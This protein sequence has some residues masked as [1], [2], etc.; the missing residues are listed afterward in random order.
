MSDATARILSHMNKDHSVAVEDYLS[1]YGGVTVDNKVANV[2]MR[3][4]ELDHM[5]IG[6]NH[7]LI[8][9]EVLKPIPFDPPMKS[10]REARERLVAMAK[11]AAAK[12]GYSHI[13][14]NEMVYPPK[15]N[16]P[17]LVLTVLL[18]WGFFKPDYLY[19]VV[20]P[21]VLPQPVTDFVRFL[22]P[23]SFYLIAFLHI[24]ECFLCMRPRLNKHRVPLDFKIEWM[25][26]CLIEGFPSWKRFDKLVKKYEKGE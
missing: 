26:D 20:Y 13:S 18:I 19:G 22:T 21:K 8:E 16:Y 15:Q 11:E 9:T 4:I 23:F 6:F 24:G 2:R 3:D 1:V 14:I 17:V 7:E 5:T 25:L 10:L 12:R